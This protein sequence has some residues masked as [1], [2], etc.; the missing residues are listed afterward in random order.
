MKKIITKTIEDKV[1]E[2]VKK[3]EAIL[4]QHHEDEELTTEYYARNGGDSGSDFDLLVVSY[5]NDEVEEALLWTFKD[6]D[7]DKYLSDEPHTYDFYAWIEMNMDHVDSD[8]YNDWLKGN[9]HDDG[10]L[11]LYVDYLLYQ[12]D[13]GAVEYTS[14]RFE[15]DYKETTLAESIKNSFADVFD[16]DVWDKVLSDAFHTEN[17]GQ[18]VWLVR[19]DSSFY[20]KGYA[21]TLRTDSYPYI[22]MV[23]SNIWQKVIDYVNSE[24]F[25]LWN[26]TTNVYGSGSVQGE[27]VTLY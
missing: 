7:K 14:G 11:S 26:G 16:K 2:W 25:L 27:R 10:F 19:S 22:I 8:Y 24:G 4:V 3:N 23:N 13:E 9:Y 18:G 6:M 15:D 1:T 20:E 12:K 5:E 17:S 21:L